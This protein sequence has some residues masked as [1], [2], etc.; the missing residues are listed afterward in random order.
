[1]SKYS[2]S[3]K[4]LY[5]IRLGDAVRRRLVLEAARRGDV[6]STVAEEALDAFLPAKIAVVIDEPKDRRG[7]SR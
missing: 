4:K 6:I 1:L 2:Q 7:S 3:E 5:G